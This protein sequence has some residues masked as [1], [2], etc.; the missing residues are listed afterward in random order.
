MKTQLALRLEHHRYNQHFADILPM[1]RVPFNFS[2][3][4]TPR[5]LPIKR[6]VISWEKSDSVD[7]RTRFPFRAVFFYWISHSHLF[8]K[9]DIQ[10]ITL[11]KYSSSLSLVPHSLIHKLIQ[12]ISHTYITLEWQAVEQRKE[13]VFRSWR[14]KE[15]HVETKAWR[16]G[17]GG[18][19]SESRRKS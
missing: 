7:M 19:Q 6:L 17:M 15:H 18:F 1:K 13:D 2:W 4:P 3:T 10:P 16:E 9:I 11:H 5:T 12:V 14:N 8:N